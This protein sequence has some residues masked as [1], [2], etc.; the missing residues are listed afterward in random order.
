MGA[1]YVEVDVD[2]VAGLVCVGVVLNAFSETTRRW[3]WVARVRTV[4]GLNNTG[5]A[6]VC[7]HTCCVGACVNHARCMTSSETTPTVV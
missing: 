4:R 5:S 6:T 7:A 1:V 3:G 2:V